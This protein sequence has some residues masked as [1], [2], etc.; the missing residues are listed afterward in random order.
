MGILPIIKYQYFVSWKKEDN[1][2]GELQS[3]LVLFLQLTNHIM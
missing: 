1:E 3:Y 2:A